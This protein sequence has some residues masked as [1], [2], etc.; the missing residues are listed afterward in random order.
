MPRSPS[1]MS[2]DTK[3][4]LT[5][6]NSPRRTENSDVGGAGLTQIMRRCRR[7][8]HIKTT[9][10]STRR[11]GQ[12]QECHTASCERGK[13]YDW[14]YDPTNAIRLHLSAEHQAFAA[15]AIASVTEPGNCL[16]RPAPDLSDVP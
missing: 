2:K 16:P 9:A 12:K 3:A 10:G 13:Y 7:V 11:R 5:A 1:W 8:A 4:C 14:S 6:H 15:S